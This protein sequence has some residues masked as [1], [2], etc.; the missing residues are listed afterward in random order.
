[1]LLDS[2]CHSVSINT[3]V[4]QERLDIKN[5]HKSSVQSCNNRI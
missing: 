4:A 3:T 1:M 5:S 2:P